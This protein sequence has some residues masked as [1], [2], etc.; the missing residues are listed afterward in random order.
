[1]PLESAGMIVVGAAVIGSV[2]LIHYLVK[3]GRRYDPL[4]VG[5][6]LAAQIGLYQIGRAAEAYGSLFDLAVPGVLLSL[7]ALIL[8]REGLRRCAGRP[9]PPAAPRSSP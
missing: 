8:W 6:L 1:M 9:K 4:C 2:M 3:A 7:I 5:G